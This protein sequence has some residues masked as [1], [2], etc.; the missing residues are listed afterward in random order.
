[1]RVVVDAAGRLV[2]PARFRAAL[3]FRKRQEVLLTLDGAALRLMTTEAALDAAVDGMQALA[4]KYSGGTGGE[5]EAF[6]SER[7]AEAAP[8]VR[9]RRR[10]ASASETDPVSPRPPRSGSRR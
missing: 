2:V 1:M 10:S 5:V 6:L 4:R 8:F 7:R 3:G 9:L